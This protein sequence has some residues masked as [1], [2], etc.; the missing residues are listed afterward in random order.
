M[1]RFAAVLCSLL[2]VLALAVGVSAT[3]AED[4]SIFNTV[5]NDGSCQ[6][7]MTVTLHIDQAEEKL[8]FPVPKDAVNITLNGNRVGTEQT[9][10]ARLIDLSK[11]LGGMTGDFSFTVNYTLYDL[12]QYVSED[13]LQLS[14]PLLSGFGYPV[15]QLQFSVTMPGVLSVR[16][17]FYSGYHQKNIEKDLNY[18][19]SGATIAGRSWNELKDHETLVMTLAVTEEMFPQSH[20]ELPTLDDVGTAVNICAL[21]AL[22]YWIF[23]LR[24]FPFRRVSQTTP[25][26]GYGAGQ[27]VSVLSLQG[28]DLSLMAFSWA[29]LGYLTIRMDRRGHVYLMKRMDMGN[30]RSTFEQRCFQNLFSRREQ[31][32]TG[33]THYIRQCQAAAKMR[34]AW[35][36]FLRRRS[37]NI[38]LFRAIIS[39]CGAFSAVSL[40]VVFSA[41]MAIPWLLIVPM[42]LLGLISCVYMLHWAEGFFL[43]RRGKLWLAAGLSA[44]WLL[45]GYLAGQIGVSVW[46]SVIQLIGGLL[47]FFGGQRTEAGKQAAAEV[48]SLRRYMRKLSSEHIHQLQRGNPDFF[49]DFAPHAMALG[50]CRAFARRFG[51]LR[52]PPCPYILAADTANLTAVQWSQLMRQILD[53]MNARQRQMPL[54]K[55]RKAV[56]SVR[57]M[58][59]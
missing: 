51:K 42:G 17:N 47:A 56:R 53:G 15:D 24:N 20:I 12:V 39:L 29:Q 34:G 11:T 4:I 25:P 23:F 41:S 43:H 44:V 27:M 8:T 33:S 28:A 18:S 40:A 57:N 50:S 36:G 7:T 14:L 48:L 3:T 58:P 10:S 31:V 19:V 1:S 9:G 55:M 35:Q 13:E 16:P 46:L 52:L 38:K 54:E 26:E 21:V 30:E 22:V 32:D 6:V 49:Y 59:R 5:S 37:G 45:L 2:L